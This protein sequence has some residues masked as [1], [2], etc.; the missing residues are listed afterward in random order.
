MTLW[1]I[2]LAA[3]LLSGLVGCTTIQGTPVAEP[4]PEV[5]ITD[6]I[7][8]QT[9]A[10]LQQKLDTDPDLAPYKLTVEHVTVVNTAGNAYKGLAT[11]VT[12]AGVKHE[13]PMDITRD[14]DNTIWNVGKDALAFIDDEPLPAGDS[15]DPAPLKP[16]DGIVYILTKSRKTRCEVS[17]DI[18]SCEVKFDPPKYIQGVQ[19][20]GA[21]FTDGEMTWVTGTLEG[22]SF[23]QMDY[24]TYKAFGWTINAAV[25]GTEFVDPSGNSM[26]VST[27]GVTTG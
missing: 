12:H 27:S 7:A 16:V 11:V 3:A 17:K 1:K 21:K 15:A 10:T 14:N 13:I 19:V 18:V 20:T 9:K 26:H 5:P 23:T 2:I 22:A 8:D 4:R 24:G 6:V 25:D